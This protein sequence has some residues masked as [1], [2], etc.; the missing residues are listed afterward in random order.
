MT[1]HTGKKGKTQK[2]PD[3]SQVKNAQQPVTNKGPFVKRGD[4]SPD[5]IDADLADRNEPRP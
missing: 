2:S 5:D 4:K 3:P 1:R